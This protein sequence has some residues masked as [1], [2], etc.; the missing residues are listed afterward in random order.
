MD[1]IAEDPRTKTKAFKVPTYNSQNWKIMRD[2]GAFTIKDMIK[3]M[4]GEE[5]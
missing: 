2:L 5:E 1:T 3:V 4:A